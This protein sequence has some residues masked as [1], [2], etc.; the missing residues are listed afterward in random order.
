MPNNVLRSGENFEIS[1][2]D[3][4]VH[5]SVVNRPD[6]TLEA[7]AECARQMDEFLNSEVFTR[8]SMYLGVVFDVRSGPA[9]FGPKTRAA[10]E[11]LFRAAEVAKKPIAARVG[12][13]AIQRLQF[14]S[15]SRECAP[16]WSRVFDQD[17]DDDWIRERAGRLKKLTAR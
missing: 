1:E 8:D 9:V 17:G 5:V 4:V 7:G 10:L 6:I 12:A 11:Q 16:N 14:N 2:T 3:G 15:V 13:A